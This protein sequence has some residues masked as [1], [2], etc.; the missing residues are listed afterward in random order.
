MNKS[1]SIANLAAAMAK[2]QAQMH[3][4]RFDSTNP[5]FKSKFASLAAVREAVIP[6][7]A[8]HGLS[9]T[10]F[11]VTHEGSA[12]CVNHLAHESGEWMEETFLIPTDKN[13]AHGYASALTYAKRLSMQSV[14]GV[15][16][17]ED[18]D[19]NAAADGVK[20]VPN[21]IMGKLASRIQNATSADELS[22][23]W[24]KAVALCKQH[25]DHQAH[26]VF[27]KLVSEASNA[28]KAAA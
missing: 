24:K 9:L 13:N 12:G 26:A 16:G 5:H 4:P 18:D 20:P 14:A 6:V 8:K 17:D 21:E 25:N 10:Q 19:G 15:V 22:A 1:P 27:K 7:L 3:N 2:A 23:I 11:P 28:M